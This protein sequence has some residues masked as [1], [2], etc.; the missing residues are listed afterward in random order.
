MKL[1]NKIK[2]YYVMPKEAY[3]YVIQHLSA[4]KLDLD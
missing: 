2:Q 1:E 3:D 4:L